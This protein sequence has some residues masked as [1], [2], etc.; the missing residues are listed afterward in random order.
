[1]RYRDICGGCRAR[2]YKPGGTMT[3]M[4]G[5]IAWPDTPQG[6]LCGEDPWCRYQPDSE[7]APDSVPVD[8]TDLALLD[9]LQDDI[10]LVSRPY[11]VIAARLGIPAE[12]VMKRLERLQEEGIVRGLSP[13]L[14]S[15]QVGLSATTLVA[16]RVPDEKIPEVARLINA[17]HEVSHNYRRDNTYSLWFTIAGKDAHRIREILDDDK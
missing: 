1:M 15:R 5:S 3:D 14:E 7:T 11:D 17:Y 2:S 9:A 10:P 16:I 12:D 8:R 4:C 6:D 13:V